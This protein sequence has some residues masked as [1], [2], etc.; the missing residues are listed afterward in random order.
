M[1][2]FDS[3]DSLSTR[4]L[5]VEG[6]VHN[7]LKNLQ[8]PFNVVSSQSL[9][10]KGLELSHSLLGEI[11]LDISLEL[12]H[13]D[14]HVDESLTPRINRLVPHYVKMNHRKHVHLLLDLGVLHV[15]LLPG[16]RL[17]G[18]VHFLVHRSILVDGGH[19]YNGNLS[20]K[21][22]LSNPRM[23]LN[24]VVDIQLLLLRLHLVDQ[25]LGLEE[26]PV[27]EHGRICE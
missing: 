14:G 17:L 25:S 3:E 10:A 6:A 15:E 21:Q 4:E 5:A 18:E 16:L 9:E 8:F 20:V 11:L 12:E 27:L 23:I 19:E 22:V 1:A 2:L 7:S 26:A 24:Q 13:D